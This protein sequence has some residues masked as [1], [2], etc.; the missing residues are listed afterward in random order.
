MTSVILAGW[1]ADHADMRKQTGVQEDAFI[2]W[3]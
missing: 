1:A 3:E 2:T